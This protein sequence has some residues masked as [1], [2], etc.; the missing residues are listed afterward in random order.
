M[1]WGSDPMAEVLPAAV[2]EVIEGFDGKGP[3]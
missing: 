3:L 2:D 1:G